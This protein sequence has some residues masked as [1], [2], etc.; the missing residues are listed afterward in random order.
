[1]RKG[2][3]RINSFNVASDRFV[4]TLLRSVEDCPLHMGDWK[5]E[6]ANCKSPIEDSVK[7]GRGLRG[8]MSDRDEYRSDGEQEPHQTARAARDRAA[9]RARCGASGPGSDSAGVG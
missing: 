4:F 1:M 5:L 3:S 8:M 7:R 6:N 9:M 2:T